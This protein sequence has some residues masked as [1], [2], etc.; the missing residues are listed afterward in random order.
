MISRVRAEKRVM[1]AAKREAGKSLFQ[2]M[3]SWSFTGRGRWGVQVPEVGRRNGG[4]PKEAAVSVGL[5][6]N[7]IRYGAG[8][9]STTSSKYQPE[10]SKISSP[11]LTNPNSRTMD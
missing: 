2:P 6:V 1:T 10:A 5:P 7:G 9:V 3:N 11:S 8:V 4:A